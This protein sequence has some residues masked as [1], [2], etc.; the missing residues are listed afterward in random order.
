M[1]KLKKQKEKATS[2]N[3]KL[4]N[5]DYVYELTPNHTNFILIAAGLLSFLLGIYYVIS[6]YKTNN[7]NGFPLDDP[8]IHLTFAKNLVQYQSFS[9]FKNDMVTAGSTSPLYTLILAGFYIVFK[10][11]MILSY[12]LGLIFLIVSTI[13]FLK[14]SLLDFSKETIYAILISVILI[15]DKWINFISVS[16]METTM[17]ILV[18]LLTTYFYKKRNA[19]AFA[20]FFA[21]ILWTRPDGIAFI[22]ALAIDYFICI[23]LSK[24]DNEMILF[25][26]KEFL[27]IGIIIASLFAI[28]FG[29]NLYLSGSLLPNTYNAKL[30]YYSPEFRSRGDFFKNEVWNY[31]TTGS[32]GIVMVGFLAGILFSI[33]NLFK[34][35]Y[36]AR[37]LYIA[38][39]FALVFIYW[40]KL[41]YA[42]RFGRYMM[43]LIP[44]FILTSGLGFRDLFKLA[45]KYF[46]SRSVAIGSTILVLTITLIFSVKNYFGN[47]SSY[48][49]ECKYINDRQVEAAK[50]IKENTK[51]EDI[52]ATHDVGAIGFYSD[53]KIIDIAGLVTPELITKISDQNYV[54]YMTDFINKSNVTYVAFLREWY[55]VVNQNPLFSTQDISPNEIMEIYKYEPSKTHILPK[56]VNSGLMEVQNRFAS[57]N[58]QNIQSG[59]QILN[60][61]LPLDPNSSLTYLLLAYGSSLLN[62]LSSSEK[63][64]LK[65]LDLYPQYKDALLQIAHLYRVQNKIEESKKYY[66][67]YLNYYPA[68]NKTR[69]ILNSLNEK[70]NK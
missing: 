1:A 40:Y 56:L 25:S 55:R 10:N 50:W 66:E 46:N 19:V 52:I 21:L 47:I 17:F 34:K 20:V 70:T 18:L 11:E 64:L 27:K 31:F 14:I 13:F 33:S 45:G 38:F 51:E 6:A 24:S 35:R 16:G 63:Y 15:S 62:D 42:H 59:M 61:V 41:P 57:K 9:Y 3:L 49:F 5:Y 26:K 65:S 36:D 7:I 2:K 44:F 69:D 8:W 43:P 32:Y 23:Y 54:S 28:Y 60:Q 22:G 53:R 48:A 39:I 58:P 4:I 29:M 30:A 68:D 12:A 67:I 37:L